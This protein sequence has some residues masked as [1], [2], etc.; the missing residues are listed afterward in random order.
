MTTACNSLWA[1]VERNAAAFGDRVALLEPGG[2]TLSHAQIRD[3]VNDT[4]LA[5]NSLG[6]G[7]GDRVA[8]VLPQ[9]PELAGAFLGVAAGASCAPLNPAYRAPQFEF[10]LNDLR[11]RALILEQ[12]D[13]TPAR[14]VALSLGV[15]IVEL[16]PE[17]S[18]GAG[19]FRLSGAPGP[20]AARGG[21]ALPD[22]VAL[23][24]HTSGTTSRPKIVPLSHANVCCS[25][26]HIC[27]TLQLQPGDRC[28]N[29]MPLFHI[30]GL[31]AGVLA[32]LS[33]GGSVICT[34]T[35][36]ASCFFDWL[37][38]WQPTWYT[39]VPTMHQA[40]LALSE[41]ALSRPDVWPLRFIR[42]SSA[43]LPPAI[44]RKLE[45]LFGAPLIESYGMTEAAHQ[46][47]S[48]PLPPRARKPGSVGLPAGPE[49]AIMNGDGEL[50][51][52]GQTGEIVI[53]GPN[54]SP[55]YESN[56]QANATAFTNG[57]FRTGDQGFFDTEGYLFITGRLKELINRG[58]EK[59][60]PREIDEA[61]LSHPGV[62]EAVAFATRHPTL[63]EDI[64]AAVV[65]K[66]GSSLSE[67]EL[68]DFTARHLPDFKVPSQIIVVADI[69]KGPTGKVQRIGLAD[70]LIKD[71]AVA[72]EPPHEGLEQLAA[73]LFEQVLSCPRAGRHD[74][75]FALGGDSLRAMQVVARLVKSLALEI[76]PT[77][78]FRRPTPAQL[79]AELF[80][81]QE[82]LEV[83][84][85][86]VELGRLPPEEVARL[87]AA[88]ANGT[89]P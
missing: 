31:I 15:P 2:A 56:P 72:Y 40:I 71:L 62:R 51:D 13:Q 6:F 65:A 36:D 79:A 52:A 12:G 26:R 28:L 23:V 70:R 69:P 63:G 45:S 47:A 50:L 17:R 84:I 27:E 8:L 41:K 82:E 1:L 80:R 4:V 83:Q 14:G 19:R 64:A 76:P 57:W 81:L 30:H 11:A 67:V 74:N 38:D 85:L 78:L 3:Q 25:A 10:Y 9:G 49:I 75:F 88:G 61:L 53:R 54:V 5:L 59:V 22:E 24:L 68:R 55:G 39:A 16:L 87:L 20:P 77:T 89:P 34:P 32:T 60:A 7:R 73:S 66:D 58:G 18:R 35:F 48:N 46:M 21:F 33:S 86:A 37:Q 44:M 29:V 42:S 43:A